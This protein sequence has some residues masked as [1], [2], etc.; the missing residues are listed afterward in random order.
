MRGAQRTAL[1]A[2]VL[3]LATSSA[4]QAQSRIPWVT[5]WAEASALA[6]RHQQLVLIHFVSNNCPPC[7]K[8]ERSVYNQPEVIRSLT[9]SYVPLKVNVDE[10][11]ELAQKYQVDTCPTDV[12]VTPQGAVV[13]R[14]GSPLEPNRYIATLDQVASHARIGMP[15]DGSP[16]TDVAMPSPIGAGN[17]GLP[18]R[19][20]AFPAEASYTAGAGSGQSSSSSGAFPVGGQATSVPQGVAGLP[21]QQGWPSQPVA[22]P[23]RDVRGAAPQTNLVVNPYATVPGQ[24]GDLMPRPAEQHASFNS[25]AGGEFQPQITPPSPPQPQRSEFQPSLANNPPAAGTSVPLVPSQPHPTLAAEPTQAGSTFTFPANPPASGPQLPILPQGSLSG[26]AETP[27]GQPDV[28]L[29]G[30][31]SVTLVEQEKWVK[32]DP[33]WGAFHLGRI[34][35]FTGPD[36]QRRFMS[37]FDKYAPALSG[38]DCVKFAQQGTLVEGKRA[39]GVFYRGQVYLFADE[40]ALQTFWGG[41]ERYVAQ[42][43]AHEQR[44]AAR[45]G[46]PAR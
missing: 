42:V 23:R 33:R 31:C 30:Y 35:L 34:Y 22:D 15:F 6:A 41:P 21:Q 24:R 13:Y 27:A 28:A 5:T 18:N 46:N 20:S 8:L 3:L 17:Q 9:A 14:G 12:I 38:F 37:N 7:I 19:A 25:P 43:R 10:S 4:L 40:S 16:N 32:G 26:A 39:H 1:T 36:E 2:I 11:R 29:E 44:Q 45:P